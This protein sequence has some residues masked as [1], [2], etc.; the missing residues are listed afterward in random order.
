MIKKN[1]KKLSSILGFFVLI[2]TIF[3]QNTYQYQ[4]TVDPIFALGSGFILVGS[5][6]KQHQVSPLDKSSILALDKNNVNRFDRMACNNWNPSVAK[7]SDG[8][9][10]STGLMY[11]YFLFKSETRK[12]IAPIAGVAMQSL[13]LSQAL[14]NVFKLTLRN[15]PYMYNPSVT[16]E[17]KIKTDSR[18]SFFSAHTST[19]SSMCFSFAL[20]HQT[21]FPNKNKVVWIG[22]FTVPAIEGLLRVKAGKHYP[23]DVIAGYFVG[24]ASS[25][26]MHYIH[27]NKP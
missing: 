22:A 6:Y 19:V 21:Y 27:L 13:F 2:Q 14:S 23:T 17:E 25:L 16:M 18:M 9:A 26:L 7:V 8:L 4:K 5:I 10:L 11:S 20:A 15:R 1:F 12:Q 24:L 3:G